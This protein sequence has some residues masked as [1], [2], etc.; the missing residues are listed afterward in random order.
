MQRRQFL[1]ASAAAAALP[2]VSVAQPASERL[3]KFVPLADLSALDPIAASSNPTRNHAYM[4]YD[5]L[6]GADSALRPHP[7]M[8]EG[9]L[10]EDDGRL[11]T[12]TL[13]EGLLFHDGEKVRAADAV[14][15]LRRWMVRSTAFGDKLRDVILALD[16]VDDRRLRFRL[17]CPFPFLIEALAS[18][19]GPTA[20]I[21]P[22]RMANTDPFRPIGEHVGSGPFR[23][24][25]D[26]YR[27]GSRA[28]YTRFD[29]YLP[30]PGGGSG[31]TAGAKRVH[32]DR[33]EWLT[34]DY[35]TAGAALQSGEIDWFEQVPPELQTLL[36][37]RRDIALDT[38][39]LHPLVATFRPNRLQPPFN[40]KRVLKAL[41]PAINQADF[42]QAVVGTDPLRF[43]ADAGV[44]TPGSPFAS[45]AGL[46]PLRGPRDLAKARRLLR[47][48][49]YDGQ[50]IRL[51]GPT[52][53]L[54]PAVLTQVAADMLRRLEV[55]LDLALTDWGGVVQRRN[56][57][58]TLAQG[59]W[60]CSCFANSSF[61][62]WSPATHLSLRG[63]GAAGYPGWPD[64]PALEALRDQWFEAPNLVEQQRIAREMQVLAMDELP[65]IPLGGYHSVTAYRRNL[66]DRVK[67]FAI[68]WNLRRA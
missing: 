60:S 67:G 27:Q 49:G 31:L 5:T 37:R 52:D 29:R 30:S 33:V 39:D 46:E 26:E 7:Q 47:E 66:Q 54:A 32:F 14:A 12:I 18:P 62:F 4:I 40:D 6:Y 2:R 1:A 13:R 59:G 28:V 21:M 63:N 58:G 48:A 55:N 65:V 64:V 57:K 45:D 9:H 53:I 34:M 11:C 61:D 10:Y 16:V 42:M 43:V 3:L 68:F 23:F 41:L 8:A 24:V 19:V 38:M 35:A 44:F 56:N 50:P 17:K 20:F 22:E 25:A 51:M 15:S 36:E